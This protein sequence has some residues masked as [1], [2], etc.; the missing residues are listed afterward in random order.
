MDNADLILPGSLTEETINVWD[1][2]ILSTSMFE[3]IV[4]SSEAIRRVTEQVMR[5]APSDATV[6][7]PLAAGGR[8]A[9]YHYARRGVNDVSQWIGSP[10]NQAT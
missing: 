2:D 7:L 6:P 10:A 8:G 9:E 4:G 1:D 3:G 5:V